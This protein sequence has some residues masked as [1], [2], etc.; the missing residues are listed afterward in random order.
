MAYGITTSIIRGK[1]QRLASSVDLGWNGFGVERHIVGPGHKPE[2]PTD[3][4]VL[5]ISVGE[6]SH[7]RRVNERGRVEP[8]T[9]EPDTLSIFPAGGLP[10]I[11]PATD[12]QLIVC[13]FERSFVESVAAESGIWQIPQMRPQEGVRDGNMVSLGHLLSNEAASRGLSGRLYVDHLA[14]ALVHRLL[15]FWGLFRPVTGRRADSLPTRPMRRVLDRMHSDLS[16]DLSLKELADE[17]GF[18]RNHFIRIFQKTTGETPHRYLLRQRV[19]KAKAL[20]RKKEMRLIDVA[21]SCGFS[22]EAQ[23][24]RVFRSLL[25]TTPSEYRRNIFS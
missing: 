9:K 6:A 18:S 19:E 1:S 16:A 11:Y 14:R 21:A 22:S 3:L 12:T 15:G 13:A 24:S 25:G 10:A 7:G 2:T 23:L 4:L 5:S 17:S 20:I 8:Y